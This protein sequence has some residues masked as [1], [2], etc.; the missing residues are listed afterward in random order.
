MRK[1]DKTQKPTMKQK[2]GDLLELPADLLADV[3]HMTLND[4][5]EIYI[6]NYKGIIEYDEHM[7]RL[8]SKG[9]TIRITGRGLAIYSITDEEIGIRG[10][11]LCIE[12]VA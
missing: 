3:P 11:I 8:N 6:E 9:Y 12:F 1:K 4:N 5:Q 2:L 7:V 10:T